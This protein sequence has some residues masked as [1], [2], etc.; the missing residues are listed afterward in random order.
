MIL[1]EKFLTN[2]LREMKEFTEHII[3]VKYD[4]V[5]NNPAKEIITGEQKELEN[6]NV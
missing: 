5:L 3:Y 6:V 1:N 2:E 4:T